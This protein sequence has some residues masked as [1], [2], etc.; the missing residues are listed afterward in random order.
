[1]GAFALALLAAAVAI[2]LSIQAQRADN[3]LRHSLE[4]ESQ[5]NQIQTLITDAETGQRGYLLTGKENYL[6][7]YEQASRQLG[8]ELDALASGTTDN[9]F[10]ARPIGDLRRSIDA[11]LNE[12]QRTI[13]LRSSNNA[14]AALAVVN[15]DSGDRMMADI[16]HIISDMR[17]EENIV[18]RTRAS[19]ASWLDDIGRL[20]LVGAVFLMAG[21]GAL[22]LSDARRR[23]QDLRS[24]NSRL[25]QETTERTSAETQVRQLQK[26]EAIGKLTGG[27]AHDFNNMLAVVIGSLDIARRRLT[28][29]GQTAA[30]KSI[31]NALEGANRAAVLT[32]R[33]LAFSRQQPL[34]PVTVDANKLVGGM[35]EMLRRTI[36]ETIS[37]ETV[38]GGGLWRIFSDPAQLESALVNL[39]VNARDAMPSG[40]R[41]TIETANTEL[42]DRYAARHS[43]VKPGQY[44]MISVTDT[45]TGMPPEV[46][47]HA[48]DPFYTTKAPGK[49]TGLGLSQVFG[50]VKQSSGHVKIY[51]EPNHGTTVKIYLPRHLGEIQAQA[52]VGAAA[53]I[54]G[55]LSR[56]HDPRCR[57]RG[58][59]PQNDR[60]CAGG[61]WL[62]GNSGGVLRGGAADAGCP[63]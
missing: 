26:M 47:E 17:E 52:R 51:S 62:H 10:Y 54:A 3:G 1:M 6:V 21:F 63:S 7:P 14:E 34:E 58:C 15:D 45:G 53:D 11:K 41:L 2:F 13:A 56:H 33:L 29:A 40:G 27:I 4:V 48:F 46:I 16:R 39:T 60:R 22:A 38:L 18:A 42:D 28:A 36:G 49:G 23:I 35:S 37:V 8:P 43:E 30:L 24:A 57:G 5:L 61:A 32:A 44:V 25:A 59:G 19:R 20:V 55:G 12:L 9:P 31:D 50:F